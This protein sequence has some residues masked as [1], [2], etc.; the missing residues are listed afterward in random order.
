M[1][2][3]RLHASGRIG[4]IVPFLICLD[5]TYVIAANR[6][7]DFK[8]SFLTFLALLFQGFIFQTSISSAHLAT[9]AVLET[10]FCMS[11]S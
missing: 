5:V 11:M 3:I 1:C 7:L 9:C 6:S 4:W 10:T 2:I 8:K